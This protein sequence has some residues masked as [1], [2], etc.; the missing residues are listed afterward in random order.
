MMKSHFNYKIQ[1]IFMQ[2]NKKLNEK[3]KIYNL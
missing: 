1:I 3:T 2:N